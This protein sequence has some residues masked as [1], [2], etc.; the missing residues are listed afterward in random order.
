MENTIYI[1]DLIGTFV[2][3]ISGAICAAQKK[4]DLF[5]VI[6]IAFVT[7]VGGGMIR[8]VLMN[9]HPMCWMNDTNYVWVILLAVFVTF[10]FKNE[11]GKLSK[12]MFLF[13]T[14]G[15]GVFTLL[16]VQK[17]NLLGFDP[18]ICVIMGTIS[19]VMGGVTRDVLTN[20]NPIIFQKEI[21]ASACMLGGISFLVLNHFNINE[22]INFAITLLVVI[23]IRLM[24]VKFK[25]RLPVIKDNLLGRD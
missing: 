13:D 19:S 25:L 14:M 9:S 8:D 1:L 2:F 17:A 3:A 21:Y 11:I 6:I 16:G 12:T 7:A 5:G 18:V 24:A 10:L 23:V 4:L 20:R 15:L 22:H